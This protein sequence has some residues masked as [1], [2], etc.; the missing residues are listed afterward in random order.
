[1]RMQPIAEYSETVDRVALATLARLCSPDSRELDGDN[2]SGVAALQ[3]AHPIYAD[4]PN[5]MGIAL[6][7]CITGFFIGSVVC[8]T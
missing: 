1:M 7:S 8:F 2:V 6:T 4:S 3:G 5:R